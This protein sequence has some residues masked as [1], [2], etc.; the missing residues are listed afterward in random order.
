VHACGRHT[1]VSA[2][3]AVGCVMGVRRAGSGREAGPWLNVG[4]GRARGGLCR[5]GG[6]QGAAESGLWGV[7]RGVCELSEGGFARGCGG[8]RENS[9]VR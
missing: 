7:R 4:R 8:R 2:A 3:G 9:L 1:S 6:I 5:V